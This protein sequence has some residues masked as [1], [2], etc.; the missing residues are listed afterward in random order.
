MDWKELKEIAIRKLLPKFGDIESK[1]ICRLLHEDLFNKKTDLSETEI[2]LLNE[3]IERLWQDEPVQYITGI[4]YFMELKLCINRSVLI[5]RPE[6][7]EL[8]DIARKYIK[9]Y[10]MKVLDIGTGSGCIALAI[11]K[12]CMQSEVMAIDISEEALTVAKSNSSQLG[13]EL[14]LKQVDFLDQSSWKQLPSNLDMIVSNPPYV[15][16]D[17]MSQ[18]SPGTVKFEPSTSLF[19]LDDPFIFYKKIALFGRSH[20]S[21][22]GRILVEINEFR[23][24]ETKSIFLEAGYKNVK[25]IHDLQGK[26]R[27]I[28]CE[29]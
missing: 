3:S 22:R 23:A 29:H 8:A 20:V 25:L 9:F 2:Q 27:F 12:Y 19:A 5:P 11:K 24:F 10:P 17:E 18:M 6:T 16:K 13:L 1:S 7:E 26:S 28:F 21:D 14:E 4:S 15:S